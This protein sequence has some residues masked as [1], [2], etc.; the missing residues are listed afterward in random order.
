LGDA[1]PT[2]HVSMTR[3]IMNLCWQSINSKVKLSRLALTEVADGMSLV[4]LQDLL[5]PTPLKGISLIYWLMGA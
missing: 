3:R 1:R 2:A 5:T 4:I